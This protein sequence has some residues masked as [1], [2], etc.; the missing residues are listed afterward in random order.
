MDCYAHI[1]STVIY[2]VICG[3]GVDSIT[4]GAG[5]DVISVDDHSDFQTSGGAE[6]VDGGIGTDKLVFSESDTN[7]TLTA[8]EVEQLIGVEEIE[9]ANGSGTATITLG[10]GTWTNNTGVTNLIIDH[11]ANTGA[12]TTDASA[13]S[14]G[15]ITV[16]GSDAV[17]YTH[18]TLP[19][20][21]YV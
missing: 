21:P 2:R 15:A 20:T 1:T 9:F 4:A 5:N 18:L 12:G 16:I 3:A 14:N 19:T 13:V 17:S 6:T 7:I 10:N 11:A 8:P